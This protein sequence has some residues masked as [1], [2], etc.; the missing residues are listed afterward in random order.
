MS[1]KIDLIG[2]QNPPKNKL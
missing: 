1:V 2:N